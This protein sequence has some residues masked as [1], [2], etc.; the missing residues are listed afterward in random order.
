[1]SHEKNIRK[2]PKRFPVSPNSV[3]QYLNFLGDGITING[4]AGIFVASSSGNL[5]V[6]DNNNNRVLRWSPGANPS[7]GGV[8]VA[9][10]TLNGPLAVVVTAN[11]QTLFVAD[12]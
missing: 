1:M 5:Y 4:A 8:L 11:E 12:S 10:D 6:V 9:S 2:K 7:T 3:S